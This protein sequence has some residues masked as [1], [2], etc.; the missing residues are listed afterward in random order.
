V[1]AREAHAKVNLALVVGPLRDDGKHEIV[2]VL[3]R[4]DLSDR[5]VLEEAIELEIHGYAEDAIVKAALTALAERAGVEPRWRVGLE[6]RIPVAAGLGGGS[7]DAAAALL[8]ANAEL[9][10]PLPLEEL[11]HVAASIGADVPFFIHEGAQLATGA[12]TDLRALDLPVGYHVLLVL[13]HGETKE[14]TGAVYTAFDERDGARGFEERRAELLHALSRVRDPRDLARL[15]RNDLAS[16]SLGSRLEDLGA[17]R[18]DVSGAGPVVYALFDDAQ[19]AERARDDVAP[20]AQT[21]L[22]RPV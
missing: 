12:G 17:L 6:K 11:H 22:A 8:L 16:S 19:L 5:L 7:S 15:P 4:I 2:T 18:A 13:P 21:W 1:S 20:V 9:P 14:S 10:H 3:Q